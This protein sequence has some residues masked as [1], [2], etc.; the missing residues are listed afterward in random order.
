MVWLT[1]V[2]RDGHEPTARRHLLHTRFSGARR[3]RQM[4]R[5]R[6]DRRFS[7]ARNNCRRAEATSRSGHAVGRPPIP[8]GPCRCRRRYN[9]RRGGLHHP[10]T[11]WR[12]PSRVGTWP[13]PGDLSSALEE[14]LKRE[15][16][17]AS[18]TDPERGKKLQILLDTLSDLG[19]SFAAKLA[20]EPAEDIHERTLGDQ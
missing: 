12:W 9:V 4:G 19:T 5:G 7:A 13:K 3:Y 14:V 6:A 10:P 17:A 20:A 1:L 18:R 8:C 11:H 15:I 16:Q 2:S